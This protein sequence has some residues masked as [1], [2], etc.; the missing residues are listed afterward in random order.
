MTEGKEWSLQELDSSGSPVGQAQPVQAPK[1]GFT[2]SEPADGRVGELYAFKVTS[3]SPRTVRYEVT[4]GA[5][6]AGLSLNKDTG[7]IT[8]VPTAPGTKRFT[9]IAR[10]NGIMPDA[11]VTYSLQVTRG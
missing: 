6:P 4:S 5:L 8:G 2:T 10:N 1:P 11:E 7:G 3:S 9:I